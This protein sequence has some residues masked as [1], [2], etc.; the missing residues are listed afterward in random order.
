MVQGTRRDVLWIDEHDAMYYTD[1]NNVFGAWPANPGNDPNVHGAFETLGG[2]FTSAPAGVARG[3]ELLDVFGLGTDFSVWHKAYRAN[4]ADGIHW[5]PDWESLGGDFSCTPVVL[6]PDGARIE[7]FGLTSD[8]SMVHRAFDGSQWGPWFALGGGFTSAPMVLGGADGSFDI[9]ARGMDFL[10][11]RAHY[12]P[13]ALPQWSKLGDGLLGEPVAASAPVAVRI[14]DKVFV[15]I[16]MA[17]GTMTSIEFD[18]ASWRPWQPLVPPALDAS[19]KPIAFISE[20]TVAAFF[21]IIDLGGVVGG[22]GSGGSVGNASSIAAPIDSRIAA[23]IDAP[24]SPSPGPAP[25][26]PAPPFGHSFAQP[27]SPLPHTFRID[28]I[29]VGADHRLFHKW[30]DANGW[31]G[32]IVD[33]Q[34]TQAWE[35]LP[36]EVTCAP[37]LVYFNASGL[38]VTMPP[39]ELSLICACTD[40]TVR[41]LQLQAGQWT[42]WPN[43]PLYTLPNCFRFS[44]DAVQIDTTRSASNDSDHAA[45]TLTVGTWL[46]RN[47]TFEMGDV[48]TGGHALYNLN[49]DGVVELCEPVVFTYSI[50]NSG[51]SDLAKLIVGG[52]VSGAASFA[53]DRIKG[54]VNPPNKALAV[55]LREDILRE[56]TVAPTDVPLAILDVTSVLVEGTAG[57]PL[58]GSVLGSVLAAGI[59]A[60]VGVAFANCDGVVAAKS[61]NFSSG[62]RLRELLLASRGVVKGQ[63][64]NLGTDTPLTCFG[65]SSYTVFWSIGQSEIGPR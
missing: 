10:I 61:V 15:F 37:G 65:N 25:P 56:M 21:P 49:F 47:T 29:G 28:V 16:V 11:W 58:V 51:N 31:H 44:A 6:S 20:P 22:V 43:G 54:L 18:G 34:E 32:A 14:H 36:L 42:T 12:V 30:M 40:G 27:P 4:A 41:P 23:P 50:V 64:Q 24:T 59:N 39:I 46:T 3:N 53:S 38:A 2:V 33:G 57:P 7:L 35:V 8:Q 62:R 55:T 1:W 26:P 52:M 17:D 13:G 19:G 48:G 60:L 5:T 9:F 45:A 63:T